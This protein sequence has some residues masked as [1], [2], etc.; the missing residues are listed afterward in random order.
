V[1]TLLWTT[2][3]LW[4]GEIPSVHQLGGFTCCFPGMPRKY[5]CAHTDKL[6]VGSGDAPD[7]L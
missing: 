4:L 5:P 3:K 7:L 2:T 1:D 6:S